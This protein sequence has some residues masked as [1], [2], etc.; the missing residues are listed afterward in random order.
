MAWTTSILATA[1][2]SVGLWRHYTA[3]SPELQQEQATSFDVAPISELT[4]GS[5]QT[6]VKPAGELLAG[7]PERSQVEPKEIPLAAGV[8]KEFEAGTGSPAPTYRILGCLILSMWCFCGC[9]ARC[10]AKTNEDEGS[11]HSEEEEEVEDTES[12]HDDEVQVADAEVQT[13]GE[14]TE[15]NNIKEIQWAH[16]SSGD[17]EHR[18][19]DL[20]TPVR[21]AGKGGDDS[22][23][24]CADVR[25]S[26]TMSSAQNESTVS[27]PR[28][29]AEEAEDDMLKAERL[30][31]EKS[32]V[33][34]DPS[35]IIF[36]EEEDE[37]NYHR[38][39]SK[40]LGCFARAFNDLLHIREAGEN[41]LDDI[42]RLEEEKRQ[43]VG[44]AA[45]WRTL[46]EDLGSK[47][48]SQENMSPEPVEAVIMA[49]GSECAPGD[50]E[51][52]TVE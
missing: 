14:T 41:L 50:E 15:M 17:V 49:S 29:Q 35:G 11:H 27:S 18:L 12:T 39:R 20:P 44:D 38:K 28:S 24:P 33:L 5:V 40:I 45:Y 34:D 48:N 26:E 1:C 36:E 7:S 51:S 8:L 22:S 10:F 42:D 46:A 2:L 13:E 52:S 32:W 31:Q 30:L 25:E 19:M 37:L 21:A 4:T 43:A 16:A 47:Q 23:A 6:H 3:P 9:C